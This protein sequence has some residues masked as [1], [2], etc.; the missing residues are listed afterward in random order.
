MQTQA[1][2][3]SSQ[4]TSQSSTQSVPS[5][6]QVPQSAR[7]SRPPIPETPST[8]AR[9]GDEAARFL[10][11]IVSIHNQ[12]HFLTPEDAIQSLETRFNRQRTTDQQIVNLTLFPSGFR[13]NLPRENRVS[14]ETEFSWG[15]K[16]QFS[17]NTVL[18]F[19]P[20]LHA[21]S[22]S[23]PVLSQYFPPVTESVAKP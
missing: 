7:S 2:Q 11:A 1:T 22:D 8:D 18:V 10:Q 9:A 13:P 16:T 14:G 23:I 12:T 20:Y 6:A 15:C 4:R 3:A 17:G 19:Q 21:G 5:Q